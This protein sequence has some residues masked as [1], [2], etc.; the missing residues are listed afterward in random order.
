MRRDILRGGEI[1]G[2]IMY[3]KCKICGEVK[4]TDEGF[5]IALPTRKAD[6]NAGDFI[7]FMCYHQSMMHRKKS[8]EA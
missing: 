5:V 6:Y 1:L 2:R 7:C 3:A 8:K 4:S